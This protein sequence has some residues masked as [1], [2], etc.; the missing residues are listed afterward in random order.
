MKAKTCKCRGAGACEEGN[1]F[2]GGVTMQEAC[3]ATDKGLY[4]KS[5][6]RQESNL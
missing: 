6:V 4:G 1:F 5:S 3:A 2:G